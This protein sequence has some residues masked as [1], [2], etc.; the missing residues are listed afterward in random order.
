[1]MDLPGW[2]PAW[3]NPGLWSVGTGLL[4]LFTAAFLAATVLPLGSEALFFAFLYAH[5]DTLL[6]AVALATLGN[7]LG[8]LTSYAAGRGLPHG[9]HWTRLQ[10]GQGPVS[11]A[12][13]ARVQRFGSASLLFA[14]AP[15]VGDALCL[16]AGWLRLPWPTCTLYMALGKAARYGALAAG[17]GWLAG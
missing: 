15:L 5:P 17:A 14:W 11:P 3:L 12:V 2:L 7:T 1:M 13:F 9:P 4:S 10:T 6:P 8:G 16:A